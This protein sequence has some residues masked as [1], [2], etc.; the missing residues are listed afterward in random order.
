MSLSWHPFVSIL[1]AL[2]AANVGAAQ[3]NPTPM[4]M[5]RVTPPPVPQVVGPD[6]IPRL[7][8]PM[9]VLKLTVQAPPTVYLKSLLKI[10][11]PLAT[12]LVPHAQSNFIIKRKV[13]V[14]QQVFSSQEGD[15]IAAFTHQGTG[16]A[17]LFPNFDHI[18]PVALNQMDGLKANALAVAKLAFARPDLLS[19]DDTRFEL[20]SP[21][22]LVGQSFTKGSAAAQPGPRP[23]L[24][25][26]PVRRLVG[27]FAVSGPGSQA[28]IAVDNESKVHG[29]MQ[30]WKKANFI[31]T[32]KETRSQAQ[33]ASLINAT[34]APYSQHGKVSV[35]SI[36]L[37][38]YDGN[39]EFMQPV[40]RYG[41]T[42]KA[43][44]GRGKTAD[45]AHLLGYIPIGQPRE[46]LPVI[47]KA[48]GEMPKSLPAFQNFKPGTV[49]KGTLVAPG[50]NTNTPPPGDPTVGRYVVRNDDPDWVNDANEFWSGLTSFGGG[51]LFTNSQYYWAEP[52]LFTT[53]KNS[54][55][56]S[57]QVALNEV[58]GNWW[59]Y[60]TYQNYGDGVQISDIPY[61]G[62]GS[63]AGGHLCYWIIH[64]CEVIPSPDDVPSST[65][66]GYATSHWWDYWFNVFGGVHSVVGYRTVM[67]IDDDAGY[68]YGQALRLG[69]PVVSS[70]LN[71]VSGLSAYSGRPTYDTHGS[72]NKPM[73]RACTISDSGHVNDSVYDTA[74]LPRSGSLTMFWFP[75]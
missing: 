20:A 75:N 4:T 30:R 49:N 52:R 21:L 63:S 40:Y 47:G 34:L 17:Q 16:E 15:R 22:A 13:T 70:W 66:P 61:P 54:F 67:Y 14:P 5:R 48:E 26:V 62:Y 53:Q 23:F 50:E 25:Y 39:G 7:S 28:V 71:T 27:S 72:T 65:D 37:A 64:S 69:L 3:G 51:G 29:F 43:P 42:I 56:N 1:V 9:Q 33:V 19:K 60:T 8:E 58:H 24:G 44:Q 10:S 74:P 73:G 68:P 6:R 46:R 57:V 38:Y 59:Y 31:G 36:D 11:A 41:V 18:K 55:I 45:D 2:T 35:D 32:V 12:D